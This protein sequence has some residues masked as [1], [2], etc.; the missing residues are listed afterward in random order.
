MRVP[1]KK[2]FLVFSGL[3]STWDTWREFSFIRLSAKMWKNYN[4]PRTECTILDVAVF[5]N[6]EYILPWLRHGFELELWLRMCL[7]AVTKKSVLEI[8]KWDNRV[9]LKMGP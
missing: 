5:F 4:I 6:L 9:C 7:K 8:I 3:S 2:H 1:G